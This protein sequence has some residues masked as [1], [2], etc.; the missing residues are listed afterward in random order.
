MRYVASGQHA[1][2]N[3]VAPGTCADG[4]GNWLP[5]YNPVT[6]QMSL[7]C[8][9]DPEFEHVRDLH[10]RL[11]E[12]CPLAGGDDGASQREWAIVGGVLVVTVGLFWLTL[13]PPRRR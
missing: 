10:E 12:E 2:S 7:V 9:S 5:I 4:S 1:F 8:P 11:R 13:R 6:E 3:N